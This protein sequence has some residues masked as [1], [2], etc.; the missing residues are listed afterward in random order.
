MKRALTD[1]GETVVAGEGM[2]ENATCPVCGRRVTLRKRRVMKGEV[3]YFWRHVDYK[4]KSCAKRA[5]PYKHY[6]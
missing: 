6:T 2:P 3:T 4:S 1:T 5:K